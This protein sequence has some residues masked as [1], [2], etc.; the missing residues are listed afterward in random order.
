MNKQVT[1][2][3]KYEIELT[4]PDNKYYLKAKFPITFNRRGC[5]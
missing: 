1:L 4:D 3:W 2:L 5:L